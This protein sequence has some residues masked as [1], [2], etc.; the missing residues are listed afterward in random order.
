MTHPNMTRGG[1][2]PDERF[3]RNAVYQSKDNQGRNT[4]LVEI[5]P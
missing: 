5:V 4:G 3:R 2:R 1:L